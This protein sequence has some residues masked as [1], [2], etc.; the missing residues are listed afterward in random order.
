MT[1][2]E[3]RVNTEKG[4]RLV[5]GGG[6]STPEFTYGVRPSRRTSS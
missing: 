4:A 1:D 2:V 6:R 3:A 5:F